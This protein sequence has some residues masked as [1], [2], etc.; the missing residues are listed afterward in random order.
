MTQEQLDE[1]V[2]DATGEDLRAIRQRGF[3]V[4][5][6]L[7]VN[8][9]PGPDQRPPLIID[10]DELD[11]ERNLAVSSQGRLHHFV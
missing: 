4:A 7:V 6:P 9:D 10:W 1:L 8:F 5:D 11:L 2:A 3:S